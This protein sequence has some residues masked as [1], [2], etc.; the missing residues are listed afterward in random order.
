MFVYNITSR[1]GFLFFTF[2]RKILMFK[3]INQFGWWS[4]YRII[5]SGGETT[6]IRYKLKNKFDIN[7]IFKCQKEIV[8]IFEEN[9]K[10]IIIIWGVMG[11]KDFVTPPRPGWKLWW[12]SVVRLEYLKIHTCEISEWWKIYPDIHCNLTNLRQIMKSKK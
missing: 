12:K 8:N 6:H 2:W 3:E 9:E 4:A 10:N 5:E 7:P 11:E 1:R